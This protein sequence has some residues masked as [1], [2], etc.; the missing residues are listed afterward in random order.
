MQPWEKERVL[1]Y[2]DKVGSVEGKV[3]KYQ[4]YEYACHEGNES[5]GI[6]M[7]ATYNS[8]RSTATKPSP[9]ETVTG[10]IGATEADVRAKF[11]APVATAGPRWEYATNNHIIPLYVFFEAGKVVRVRP[12]DLRLEQVVKSAK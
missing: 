6:A 5:L 2:T 12:D 8:R 7:I 11:G 3:V 1:S 9:S 10:L 4:M